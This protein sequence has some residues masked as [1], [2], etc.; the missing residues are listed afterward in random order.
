M[1]RRKRVFDFL[2]RASEAHILK[3]CKPVETRAGGLLVR[4]G[5]RSSDL[6]IITGGEYMVFDDSK[7]EDFVLAILSRGDIFGEMSFLDGEPRSAS[8]KAVTSSKALRMDRES[9]LKLRQEAPE[10]AW[11]LVM[12]LASVVTTRLRRAD[13]ALT[14]TT[15]EDQEE[16]DREE[17]ERLIAEMHLAVHLELDRD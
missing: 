17:L 8:V 12:G 13:D 5:D 3:V 14:L 2:D 6:F 4:A 15:S 11:E 16:V 1:E 9:L 7:G 10:A